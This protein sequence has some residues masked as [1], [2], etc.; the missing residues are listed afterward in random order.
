MPGLGILTTDLFAFGAASK[1]QV[2]FRLESQKNRTSDRAPIP[3]SFSPPI[4][5]THVILD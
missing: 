4:H 2:R 5:G 1:W 3:N